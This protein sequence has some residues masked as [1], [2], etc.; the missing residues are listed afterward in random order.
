MRTL[1]ILLFGFISGLML[2]TIA[3]LWDAYFGFIT[4]FVCSV[5]KSYR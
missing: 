1:V 5:T 4:F 2:V 3:T